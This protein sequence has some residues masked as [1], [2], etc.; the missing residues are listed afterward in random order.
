MKDIEQLAPNFGKRL[1]RHWKM[2]SLITTA[3]YGDK[4]LTPPDQDITS[5]LQ[6][7]W[8]RFMRKG[9]LCLQKISYASILY[10]KIPYSQNS[11]VIKY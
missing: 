6:A 1:M 10:L 8:R 11:P 9:I 4:T 3:F 5:S 7:K 2:G